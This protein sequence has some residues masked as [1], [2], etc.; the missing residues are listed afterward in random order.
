MNQPQRFKDGTTRAG[1]LMKAGS[2]EPPPAEAMHRAA[3][4]LGVSA[5]M[6]AAM[7][8]AT[9]ASAV[10]MGMATKGPPQAGAPAVSK[11]GASG[12]AATIAKGGMAGLGVGLAL[13]AGSQFMQPKAPADVIAAAPPM[14]T[15]SAQVE[16]LAPVPTA[17][18]QLD[19]GLP[20]RDLSRASSARP[21]EVASNTAR[22]SLPSERRVRSADRTIL[23]SKSE[24]AHGID[25]A[26]GPAPQ[27]QDR[28]AASIASNRSLSPVV[29]A[30]SASAPKHAAPV[31]V[32]LAREVASL[33][34]TRMLA[35]RGDAA[36]ALRELDA[37][38]RQFGYSVLQREATLVRIDVLLSL[39][40]KAEAASAARRLLAMGASDAERARLEDLLKKRGLSP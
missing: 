26:R 17:S 32:R 7:L 15:V 23:T 40:R 20:R 28:T 2:E 5:S 19:A 31:D 27:S 3:L 16:V 18:A 1:R 11:V 22:A 14:P 9:D 8:R 35:N 37:F 10:G 13:F 25:G 29:T 21:M 24:A 33:D 34:R 36:S 12:L 38:D 4:Q 30:S 39:G 6:L